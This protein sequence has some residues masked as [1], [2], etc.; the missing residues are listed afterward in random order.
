M[1][2]TPWGGNGDWDGGRKGLSGKR[3]FLTN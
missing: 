3:Y 1:S 2:G